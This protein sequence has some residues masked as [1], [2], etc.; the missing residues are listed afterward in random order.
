MYTVTGTR[1]AGPAIS[2]CSLPHAPASP[3]NVLKA[4]A[5][6]RA[7]HPACPR[8]EQAAGSTAI[9]KSLKPSEDQKQG[10]TC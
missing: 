3:R 2:M 9:W 7:L 8:R 5:R 4:V 10:Q 1:A 6:G